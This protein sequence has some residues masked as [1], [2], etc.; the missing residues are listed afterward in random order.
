M[1]RLELHL[2]DAP[3]AVI[4]G[5]NEPFVPQ[6]INAHAFLPNS[7]RTKLGIEDNDTQTNISNIYAVG[8][9]TADISLVNVAELE[10]RNAVEKIFDKPLKPLE[11]N[12]ISTIM[13]LGPEV[14]GVG[15][16]EI[17][18]KEKGILSA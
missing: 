4:T 10:G 2:D 7:L 15:I 17:A 5:M 6:A 11:Y 18:A 14:A 13:F 8:D 1:R 16:N 12:H 3:V 9:L